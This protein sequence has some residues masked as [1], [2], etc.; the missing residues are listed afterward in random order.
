LVNKIPDVANAFFR[1]GMIET[2]GRG[3]E[4]IMEACLA[5]GAPRPEL[6]YEQTGL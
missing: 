2:W 6:R 4:W 3:I 1:T 5:A